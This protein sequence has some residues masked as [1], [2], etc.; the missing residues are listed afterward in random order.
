MTPGEFFACLGNFAP[1]QEEIS[2]LKMALIREKQQ[3]IRQFDLETDID[4]PDEEM[5]EVLLAHQE[6]Q[7]DEGQSK[8]LT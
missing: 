8:G 7:Q 4:M 5:F 1:E 6:R 2:L 3:I